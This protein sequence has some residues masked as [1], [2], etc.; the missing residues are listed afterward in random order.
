MW[1]RSS[2][3][4]RTE[5]RGLTWALWI[6]RE[7]FNFVRL[8]TVDVTFALRMMSLIRPTKSSSPRLAPTTHPHPLIKFRGFPWPHTSSSSWLIAPAG[9]EQRKFLDIYC[10]CKPWSVYCCFA[11]ARACTARSN[12][13]GSTNHSCK[14]RNRPSES[15]LSLQ[16]GTQPVH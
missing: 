5:R 2:W 10:N 7:P 1:R 8:K 12:P 16:L 9:G 4:N 15:W 14:D 3:M 11:L 13:W 6:W